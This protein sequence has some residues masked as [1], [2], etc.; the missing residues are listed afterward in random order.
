M[1][2]SPIPLECKEL[3]IIRN[4]FYFE[5]ALTVSLSLSFSWMALN[6]SVLWLFIMVLVV[7]FSEL[8]DLKIKTF[9]YLV[10][11]V[12]LSMSSNFSIPKIDDRVICYFTRTAM[13]GLLRGNGIVVPPWGTV[14]Y[15]PSNLQKL[16]RVICWHIAPFND[17]VGLFGSLISV[18]HYP[19]LVS[20]WEHLGL[21][22]IGAVS[23]REKKWRENKRIVVTVDKRLSKTVISASND[24]VLSSVSYGYSVTLYDPSCKARP[25][26]ISSKQPQTS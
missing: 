24:E 11:F 19:L 12:S 17:S 14:F 7:Q 20:C 8:N 26:N 5:W 16:C 1:V 6:V 25:C 22:E 13:S 10:S 9:K 18:C 4:P 15:S 23:K 2:R 3:L 21:S